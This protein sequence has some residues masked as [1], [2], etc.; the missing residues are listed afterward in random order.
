MAFFQHRLP[1][2]PRLV[3]ITPFHRQ[4]REIAPREVAV[5]SLVQAGELSWPRK[6]QDSSPASLGL[7]RIT[8]A[9]MHDRLA[10]P[11][12]GI[13]GVERKTLAQL[14]SAAG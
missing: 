11:E 13:F 10:E 14:A 12:L 4:R 3:E 5:D 7:S 9:P 2:L 8:A 1:L 6:R